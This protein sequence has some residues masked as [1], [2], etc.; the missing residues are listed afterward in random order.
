MTFQVVS[1]WFLAR[2][3]EWIPVG[4]VAAGA[5]VRGSEAGHVCTMAAHS[6]VCS[7]THPLL[8][9]AVCALE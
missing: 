8:I 7:L 1:V 4:S 2:R 6:H 9:V 5:A 3:S